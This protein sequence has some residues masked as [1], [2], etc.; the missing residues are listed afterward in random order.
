LG[1]DAKARAMSMRANA[2]VI[3]I[4]ISSRKNRKETFREPL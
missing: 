2:P 1:Q 3:E 4:E